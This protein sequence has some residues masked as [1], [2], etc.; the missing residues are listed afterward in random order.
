M[1]IPLNRL[2]I[3]YHYNHRQMYLLILTREISFCRK[4]QIIWRLRIG[5][6]AEM[7]DRGMCNLKSQ[8]LSNPFLSAFRAHCAGQGRKSLRARGGG[9]LEGNCGFQACQGSSADELKAVVTTHTRLHRLKP[10]K[11]S[12]RRGEVGM[13]SH[14]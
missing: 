5:Q 2:L 13:K 8:V 1:G 9:W 10:D 6:G 4:W 3:T 11:S 14:S 7:R 12:P